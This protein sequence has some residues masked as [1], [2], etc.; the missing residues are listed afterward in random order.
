MNIYINKICYLMCTRNYGEYRISL[1]HEP[2]ENNFFILLGE[3]FDLY[4]INNKSLIIINKKL[5]VNNYIKKIYVSKNNKLDD[6][7][8]I[9]KDLFN[10]LFLVYENEGEKYKIIILP[11]FK[12]MLPL[13]NYM[14]YFPAT[15]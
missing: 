1:F 10:N 4:K 11:R 15:K 14:A 9:K 2:E 5:Y 8:Y 3:D 13:Y 6:Y 7:Y 12:S